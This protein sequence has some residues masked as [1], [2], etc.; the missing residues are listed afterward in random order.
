MQGDAQQ[1]RSD[2]EFT[3]RSSTTPRTSPSTTRLTWPLAFSSTSMSP[4]P[5]KAIETGW[6][7]PEAAVLTARSGSTSSGCCAVADPASV[8]AAT[9]PSASARSIDRMPRPIV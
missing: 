3:A 5:M 9:A 2:A 4:L 7:K 1:P 6:L 8:M